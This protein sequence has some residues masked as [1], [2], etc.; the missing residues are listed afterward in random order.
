[1]ACC[2]LVSEAIT[3]STLTKGDKKCCSLSDQFNG[4]FL[5]NSRGTEA[6]LSGYHARRLLSVLKQ[7]QIGRSADIANYISK[8]L[9]F[10]FMCRLIC[11]TLLKVTQSQQCS[12]SQETVCTTK[13]QQKVSNQI[14]S[15]FNLK[16]KIDDEVIKLF[17]RGNFTDFYQRPLSALENTS[18]C[19]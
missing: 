8:F 10:D 3:A 18:L 4:W 17:T 19:C 11:V 16:S 7:Q 2:K 12:T 9:S 15:E 5:K 14:F 6:F 13:L 1:M